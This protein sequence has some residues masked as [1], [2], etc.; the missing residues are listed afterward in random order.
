MKIRAAFCIQRC[1]YRFHHDYGHDTERCIELK[2]EIEDLIRWG[3]LWKYVQHRPMQLLDDSQ[4]QSQP[5][6]GVHTQPTVSM[7]NMILVG[8]RLRGADDSKSSSKC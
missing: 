7:I 5:N 4:P 6:K 2:N 8:P 1:Y 3:Y